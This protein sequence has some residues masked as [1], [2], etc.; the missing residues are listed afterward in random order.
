MFPPDAPQFTR[1]AGPGHHAHRVGYVEAADD[2]WVARDFGNWMLGSPTSSRKEALQ[3]V[4]H[5]SG[6]HL[7][8]AAWPPAESAGRTVPV[9]RSLASKYGQVFVDAL[10]LVFLGG[11]GRGVRP[12]VNRRLVLGAV[13]ATCGSFAALPH[14]AH[15]TTLTMFPSRR[16][17]IRSLVPADPDAPTH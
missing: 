13:W 15:S 2:S 11:H 1:A 16:A 3:R 5:A 10:G 12:R 8:P 6:Y 9:P 4:L 14:G 17:A 7:T